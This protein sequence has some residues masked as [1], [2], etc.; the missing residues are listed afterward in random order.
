MRLKRLAF[1]VGRL[2]DSRGPRGSLA[3]APMLLETVSSAPMMMP[4]LSVSSAA[5]TG[6]TADAFAGSLFGASLFPWLL[7]LYWLGHG[8]VE[9]PRGVVYG[10]QYL[11][12]FVFGSIPAA[13]G[14]GALYGDSL[15]D[16]DWLHGAA[17]SL[18]AVT[19]CVVV[20]GF[21]DALAAGKTKS[22]RLVKASAIAGSV[23]LLTALAHV[24]LGLTAEHAPWLGGDLRL[25]REPA[26]ALSLA[27]W[28]IHTSS[29]VEW[30]VAMG[31][32]WRLAASKKPEYRGLTWGMLPLHSSGIVACTYHVLYNSPAVSWLVTL[33]AALTC[34]GNS[35]MAFAALRLA[36][37]SG[38]TF[39]EDLPNDLEALVATKEK[40]KEQPLVAFQFEPVAELATTSQ[41]TTQTTALPGWEDLGD[42][43]ARDEDAAFFLKLVALSV[44][45]A[46]LVKYLP[47][48]L[49]SA[50]V[51]A[52]FA[53]DLAL[54][55]A[56]ISLVV[57]P[58]SL[59]VLKWRRRSASDDDDD[60]AEKNP[61]SSSSS[62]F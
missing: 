61:D 23:A 33:Q 14:A 59:N 20:F 19:N 35:T 55:V 6:E 42:T 21:R 30:L 27:T 34:L 12:L 3:A 43:W 24:G 56:A 62:L 9:A 50:A 28:T 31:L 32:S 25:S 16:V 36:L 13:I 39:T 26:N 48:L 54:N 18:L 4:T 51:D 2:R 45:S 1:A 44:G 58:T 29:L 38:W 5:M 52:F 17:E 11:L 10:L 49:P 57:V 40:N 22:D 41:T 46:A 7:M 8:K 15:A 60:F 47:P 53:S 37:A